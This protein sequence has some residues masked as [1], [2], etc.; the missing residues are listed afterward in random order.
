MGIF[1]RTK[2]ESATVGDGLFTKSERERM[3]ALWRLT[4]LPRAEFD[5]TYGELLERCWRCV[6]GGM[7]CASGSAASATVPRPEISQHAHDDAVGLDRQDAD[8]AEDRT[9]GSEQ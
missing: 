3:D 8:R 2:R 6:A 4:A 9:D 1:K 5:A 7:A